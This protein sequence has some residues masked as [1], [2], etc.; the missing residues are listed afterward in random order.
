[1]ARAEITGGTAVKGAETPST[2]LRTR[3]GSF[4]TW[5]VSK[6]PSEVDRR[7]RVIAWVSFAA[8]V[9][10]I[11]TGGAVRLT[12]SGLGCPEWPLCTED[13]LVNT[14]EMGIHGIIEFVNRLLTFV[15]A[16]IT[17]LAFASVFRFRAKRRD[18]FWITLLQG[19]SIPFQAVLGGITVLTGL[20]PYV[21]GAHFAVSIV[22]VSLITM[23][24]WR[25]YY[26]PRGTSFIGPV[27]YRAVAWLTAA[28][29]S[30]T[31]I[32][33]ILTT[34]SGPHAGDNSN[35]LKPAPRTGFDPEFM[36][37]LHSWPAYAT[38]ALTILMIIG[39]IMLALPR[40]WIVILLA[41]ELMQTLVGLTQA[42]LGLPEILVGVH[43]VLSAFLVA[44]MTT[45]LLSLRQKAVDPVK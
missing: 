43:M 34:G 17:I 18:L 27:W 2:G 44:S 39:A 32:A 13:S 8:Q 16:A 38:L 23:L 28:A 4:T 25:V 41:V 14:P 40:R 24:L 5:F 26:G 15:L 10:L 36:Q 6:L 12:A 33:G 45:V 37:H 3:P 21:V 1:M 35:P 7:V 31:V 19:L 29:V 30:A 11:A 20:N 9:G 42:R 22:L